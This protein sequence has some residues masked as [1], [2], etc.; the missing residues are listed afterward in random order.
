MNDALNPCQC[1][2]ERT[3]S[4]PNAY[5]I[6]EVCGWEDDLSQNMDPEFA[7]GAN[8]MSLNEAR[9][10]WQATGQRSPVN[11]T[12]QMTEARRIAAEFRKTH[13]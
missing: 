10:F 11:R 1:C 5:E 7:G 2:R 9:A 3:I 8:D 12:P 6:C 13:Q 4:E